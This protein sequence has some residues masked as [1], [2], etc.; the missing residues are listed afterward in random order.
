MMQPAEN[1]AAIMFCIM[2]VVAI[3]VRNFFPDACQMQGF[4]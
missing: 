4:K 1:S 2:C 3:A